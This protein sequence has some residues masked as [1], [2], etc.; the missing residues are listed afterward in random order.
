MPK[1]PRGARLYAL[2][3]DQDWE[4]LEA[5]VFGV[6][7]FAVPRYPS[8]KDEP[9]TRWHFDLRHQSAFPAYK[10]GRYSRSTLGP[11]A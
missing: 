11:R 5:V 10:L 2:D 8:S 7:P 9:V 1:A 6:E 4:T 3:A